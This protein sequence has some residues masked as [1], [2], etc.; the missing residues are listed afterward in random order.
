MT[1]YIRK[2]PKKDCSVPAENER[3]A[4]TVPFHMTPDHK[5]LLFMDTALLCIV[6][7]LRQLHAA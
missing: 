1:R 6:L 7:R 4:G 5:S 3:K 2:A